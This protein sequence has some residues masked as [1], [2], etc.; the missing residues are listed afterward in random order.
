MVEIA[1]L[2][3]RL[4]DQMEKPLLTTQ[5]IFIHSNP[6]DISF[7]NDERRFDVEGSYN[8]RY[9]VIKKRIDKVK[10]KDKNERLTQPGK[11][12][13]IYYNAFEANEYLTYISYLQ[14]QG[15]LLAEVET[16]ELEELQ[17]ISGL[18]AL[19]VAVNYE[20]NKWS[21]T[22]ENNYFSQ[23]SLSHTHIRQLRNRFETTQR[24]SRK[25]H[26]FFRK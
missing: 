21:F 17:G 25:L 8:I 5:L 13:L 24:Y 20:E 26:E 6:I 3:N 10:I 22:S 18:K 16:L 19:R 15:L 9:E 2:T 7:R 12:A 1:R 4:V 11:I 23:S 14:E